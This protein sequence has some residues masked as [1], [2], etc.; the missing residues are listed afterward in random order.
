MNPD[1]PRAV[2]RGGQRAITQM[3]GRPEP[4]GK[5]RFQG[6]ETV[7]FVALG[8]PYKMPI[9]QAPRAVKH[10]ATATSSIRPSKPVFT[11]SLQ[12]SHQE[13]R[14]QVASP[15]SNYETSERL[16]K[17]KVRSGRNGGPALAVHGLFVEFFPHSWARRARMPGPCQRARFGA[18]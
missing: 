14:C 6:K 5:N 18:G 4:E 15:S 1:L 16:P 8:L 3:R 9:Q 10:E 13:L 7:G 17:R 12:E 2:F 11:C